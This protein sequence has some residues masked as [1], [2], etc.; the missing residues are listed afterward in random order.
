MRIYHSKKGPFRERPFYSDT[1]IE[2]IC[3]DALESV[4]LYPTE[5]GPIRIERFIEK[6]FQVTPI[7]TDKLDDGVLGMTVFGRTGVKEVMISSKVDEDSNTNVAGRRVRSTLAHEGGHGLFHTH[8]FAQEVGDTPLFGDL[9]DPNK[10]KVLC[11]DDGDAFD[12]IYKGQWWEFQAN[13]AIGSLLM[14]VR[15]VEHAIGNYMVE[16]GSMG[17]RQLDYSKE[18]IAIRELMDLFDVNAPVARIRLRQLF[19][20]QNA[21]QPLL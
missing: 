10:P 4:D 18:Q 12:R 17:F 16:V 15:L 1:D 21:G 14:P 2:N 6:R 9:T 7:Y 5:P 8:L 20:V 11:R 19:P 3:R 13:R